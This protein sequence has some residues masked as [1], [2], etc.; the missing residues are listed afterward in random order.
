MLGAGAGALDELLGEGN[1]VLGVAAAEEGGE[2]TNGAGACAG[3]KTGVVSGSRGRPS[4]RA[5]TTV[6]LTGSDPGQRSPA[7]TSSTDST[8]KR[9]QLMPARRLPGQRAW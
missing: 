5:A 1:L 2:G 8:T 6:G 3:S 7:A 9:F 4:T